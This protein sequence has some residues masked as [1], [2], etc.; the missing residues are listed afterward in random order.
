MVQ[1]AN[2]C[3]E[4]C[5]KFRIFFLFISQLLIEYVPQWPFLVLSLLRQWF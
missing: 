1:G 4:L 3:I 5:E 2:A